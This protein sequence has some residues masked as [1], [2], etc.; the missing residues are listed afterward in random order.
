M[1]ALLAVTSIMSSLYIVVVVLAGAVFLAAVVLF[2]CHVILKNH[3]HELVT[4]VW[5]RDHLFTFCSI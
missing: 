4:F 5:S 1:L 2:L 3:S